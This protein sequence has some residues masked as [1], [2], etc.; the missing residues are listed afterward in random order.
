MRIWKRKKHDEK[1]EQSDKAIARKKRYREK[2]ETEISK[3]RKEKDEIERQ[4]RLEAFSRHFNLDVWEMRRYIGLKKN[5]VDIWTRDARYAKFV[6]IFETGIYPQ[7]MRVNIT[8]KY[9]MVPGTDQFSIPKQ[10][11]RPFN[12]GSVKSIDYW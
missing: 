5:G 6:Q 2:H 3:K 4:K 11:Q 9:R 7:E 1:Y 8:A 12:R 10:P